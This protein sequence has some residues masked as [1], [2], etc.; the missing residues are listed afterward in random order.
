VARSTL[1]ICD[2]YWDDA[3]QHVRDLQ[4]VSWNDV[5]SVPETWPLSDYMDTDKHLTHTLVMCGPPRMGK[6][7]LLH[8]MGKQHCVKTGAD[9]YCFCKSIDPLGSLSKFGLVQ[10]ASCAT[11]TD[12]KLI[13]QRGEDLN[14][15]EI[16]TLF[17]A[18]EGGQIRARYGNLIFPPKFPR[19]FAVNAD[20][21]EW[22]AF[23]LNSGVPSLSAFCDARYDALRA[24]SSD[25]RAVAARVA[26][27]RI[28]ERVVS[29]KQHAGHCMVG[30][31]IKRDVLRKSIYGVP[32]GRLYEHS[33]AP[34]S[35]ME[36][37]FFQWQG[38]HR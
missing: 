7:T 16:K 6:S 35:G 34:M 17:D 1:Q 26:L 14:A 18:G 33:N 25:D 4:V 15:E 11:F 37:H 13:T 27:L 29:T 36:L 28:S 38:L 8:M 2:L 9:W 10:E 19:M 5:D 20:V 21:G 24:M 32:I 23:F 30:R 22:G 12:F 3:D 31:I